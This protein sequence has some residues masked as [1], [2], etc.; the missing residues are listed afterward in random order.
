[1]NTANKITLFRIVLVPV[2]MFFLLYDIPFAQYISAVIFVIAAVTDGVDGYV[3][4]KYDQETTFGKFIDPLAD[5]LLVTAALVGL[6]GMG[7]LDPWFALVIISREFIVTSL[8]IVAIS[9]GKVI[10]A[11]MSGK[12]KTVLQIVAIVAMLIDRIYEISVGGILLSN[13]LMIA[14]TVAT[15]YSGAEYILQNKNLIEIK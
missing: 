1:M 10:P 12:I 6:V 8:R 14:A 15:V 4:R 5:K 11:G 2:F 13:V 9:N 3:A 7:K